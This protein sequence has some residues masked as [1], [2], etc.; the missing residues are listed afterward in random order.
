VARED[1]AEEEGGYLGTDP[2]VRLDFFR[3]DLECLNDEP[4]AFYEGG[5]GAILSALTSE[6]SDQDRLDE[7]L[8]A[9]FLG[10]ASE[11]RTRERLVERLDLL[12]LLFQAGYWCSRITTSFFEM[13]TLHPAVVAIIP[14]EDPDSFWTQQPPRDYQA[15]VPEAPMGNL[16]ALQWL[17]NGDSGALRVMWVRGVGRWLLHHLHDL[18]EP[19]GIQGP[20]VILTSAT[21]WIP[22]SSFYHIPIRPTVVL[23]EPPEDR[24]ALMESRLA[25]RPR[26]RGDGSPITVSGR[27][28]AVREDAL[29]EL[30]SRLC[31][32]QPGEARSLLD[33]VRDELDEDRR[34]VLFVVLSGREAKLVTEHINTRTHFSARNVT[35]D[36][37]DLG[38]HGLHRRMVATFAETGA[39]IL[40]AAEMA[41]QRGYNILNAR[42]TAALGAVFYLTRPHPPPTDPTFPLSLIN[43]R[44]ME[45]L[46]APVVD[47]PSV[48]D[49]ARFL[50]ARAR[51]DW[52][53]LM[54]RPVSFR[55][56]EDGRQRD[57]F[58]ANSLVPLSQTI[59]RTI[60]GH[61]P[62]RVLLCDAA[63][64]PRHA[65]PRDDAAD[66]RRTSLVVAADEYLEGL[67]APPPPAADVAQRRDHAVAQAVW[68]LVGHL[69]RTRDMGR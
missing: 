46:L 47:P 36:A 21:S 12:R 69:L 55:R 44:A 39:D 6:L 26:Y 37:E 42:R 43:Q 50:R 23:R 15:L 22:G 51:A 56:L 61:R 8:D 13:A 48:G 30:A 16:L 52:Y 67:L 27:Q 38:D 29:R 68:G 4:F 63:F 24:D 31:A 54:S 2:D 41:I 18:L 10:H 45:Y 64:A 5:L 65:D 33:Q 32:P 59:G 28:G 60:R 19:E 35:P 11:E 58:V 17:P 49:A 20:H 66:T 53:G 40:V 7:A 57:A 14:L 25:F 1:V 9:W 34:Q 3:T 62:T